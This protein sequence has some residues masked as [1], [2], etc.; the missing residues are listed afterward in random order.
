MSSVDKK[1][2]IVVQL[3]NEAN[4]QRIKVST[5][6]KDLIQYCQEH[7]STDVLVKGFINR[8]N[9]YEVKKPCTII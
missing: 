2:K 1:A 5:A 6:C 7:E 9:V 8:S 3:R 4:I